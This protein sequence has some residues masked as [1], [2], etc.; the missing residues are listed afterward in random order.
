MVSDFDGLL[1][2]VREEFTGASITESEYY[3]GAPWQGAMWKDD[4]TG[5]T[6]GAK[7]SATG[8]RLWV[9]GSIGKYAHGDNCR[10]LSVEQ[11][12][13]IVDDLLTNVERRYADWLPPVPVGR[14]SLW[15]AKRAD[16]YYQRPVDSVPAVCVALASAIGNKSKLS[17]YLTS[18]QFAQ[19]RE[20]MARWYGKG[21]ESG[22]EAYQGI[23][24]HEEQVRGSKRAGYFLDLGK[25]RCNVG[26]VRAMM[27]KRYE[28][29]PEQ[30]IECVDVGSL[31]E[32]HGTAG[33]AAAAMVLLPSL[34]ATAKQRLSENTFYKYRK[35]ATQYRR[36]TVTVD[37]RVPGDAWKE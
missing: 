27:N 22:N 9:E 20:Q 36:R 28:D 17:Q 7:S 13:E 15:Q 1:R 8:S 16:F 23:L 12:M 32:E 2:H 37:L 6:M 19:S 35:L 34:E 18:V 4:S 10:L 29:W 11:S 26:E 5:L 24:R 30:G 33:M 25:M 31:I 21:E 3:K 14:R